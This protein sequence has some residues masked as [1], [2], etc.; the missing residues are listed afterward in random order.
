MP[1]EHGELTP[2]ESYFA[3]LGAE[4]ASM[5]QRI[6][7]VAASGGDTKPLK[8]RLAQIDEQ[9]ASGPRTTSKKRSGSRTTAGR[10]ETPE[11]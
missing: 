7:G 4:R 2:D 8:D 11:E 3:G 10:T 9:L 5:E 6:A 1:N